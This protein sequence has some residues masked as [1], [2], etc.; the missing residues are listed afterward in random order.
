MPN[1]RRIFMSK[2]TLWVWTPRLKQMVIIKYDNERITVLRAR[3]L[4]KLGYKVIMKTSYQTTGG[5]N[6]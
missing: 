2:F 6:G 3:S 4:A 5:T 1:N